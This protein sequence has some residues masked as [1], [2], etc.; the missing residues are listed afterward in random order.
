MALADYYRRGAVAA[1]Q[2]IAGFDDGAFRL[3]LEPETIELT[4]GADARRGE[5]RHALDMLVRLVARLYPVIAIRPRAGGDG[6]SAGLVDLARAINPNIEVTTAA[7]TRAIVVG[8][9]AKPKARTVIYVG[10]AGPDALVSTTSAQTVGRS[11]N[12]FGAGAAASF[13][14]ANI[15]RAIFLPG[16]AALLDVDLAFSTVD[17]EPHRT[18]GA[19]PGHVSVPSDAVLVGLGAIGNATAWA[20]ARA[21]VEGTIYLVDHQTV[22]L[23]NIQRYVLAARGDE[24]AV[25][26]ELAEAAFQ[27]PLRAIGC[28]QD[29]TTFVDERGH[30]WSNVLVALDSARDRRA[31]AASLPERVFNAWTQPGDLGISSHDF[32][33]GAC[34]ACLY[35]PAGRTPNEDEIVAKAL[36]VP[37]RL[38]EVRDLLYLGSPLSLS[39]LEAVAAA[40]GAEPEALQA[41][42]GR[43]VRELYVEGLCGGAIVPLSRTHGAPG[44][45]HVPLAH[46]SAL[47]GVLLGARFVTS[48]SRDA[49][50]GSTATRLDILRPVAPLPTAP[51]GKDPRG[52]CLCQDRVYIDA[53]RAKYRSAERR[54]A[55][56]MRR[57]HRV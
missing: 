33:E 44:D 11:T 46:Q 55:P 51:V 2:I 34:L 35:L 28:A 36:G 32:L 17:L 22:E 15:F 25:K 50:A 48:L 10:S 30:R 21:D 13:A 29:W 23:G 7:G 20:L 4:F 54:G 16:G 24:N 6:L 27:G 38:R 49:K 8:E 57:R 40:L 53:F 52:I 37:D 1:A 45:V 9:G 5:G 43:T 42:E 3:R 14:A 12:P 19:T 26:T 56:M 39:F 31:V 18:Q 41:F 47:A